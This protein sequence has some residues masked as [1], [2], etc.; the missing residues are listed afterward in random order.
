[1]AYNQVNY[2]GKV[3]LDGFA[4]IEERF[5][6]GPSQGQ[7]HHRNPADPN[8]YYHGGPDEP[9]FRS[10]RPPTKQCYETLY[11]LPVPQPPKQ[12]G[13]V[14]SSKQAAEIYG[15]IVFKDSNYKTKPSRWGYNYD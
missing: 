4:I 13:A 12:Q 1:M 6:R 10:Y 3:A 2:L 9:S 11:F 14:I 5:G 15:G 8:Q 7:Y